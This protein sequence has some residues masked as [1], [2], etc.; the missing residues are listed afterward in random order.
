M[1]Y[2]LLPSLSVSLLLPPFLEPRAAIVEVDDV[3]T[4]CALCLLGTTPGSRG[5]GIDF[6]S[7]VRVV[8]LPMPFRD[9]VDCD[10]R[11]P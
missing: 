7:G 11:M 4:S 3:A 1:K 2:G 5:S 9:V 6:G 10:G 8:M